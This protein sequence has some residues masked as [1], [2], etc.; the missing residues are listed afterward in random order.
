M[1]NDRLVM[2]GKVPAEYR[3]ETQANAS[4]GVYRIMQ[5]GSIKQ[6]FDCGVD[7]FHG[8]MTFSRNL[9]AEADRSTM[10]FRTVKAGGKTPEEVLE[11][12][13]AAH[14]QYYSE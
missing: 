1:T 14:D 10:D 8:E 9:V 6:T 4:E 3:V 2:R 13:Q 7:C 11:K 12:L 5:E